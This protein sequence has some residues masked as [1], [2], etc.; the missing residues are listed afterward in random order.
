VAV[1]VASGRGDGAFKRS[2]QAAAARA[3][4]T[5]STPLRA[6]AGAAGALAPTRAARK[7]A[8]VGTLVPEWS[9]YEGITDCASLPE[10]VKRA[11]SQYYLVNTVDRKAAARVALRTPQAEVQRR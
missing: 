7:A 3:L 6:A 11:R 5:A 8:P 1:E 2:R 9:L 4:V 10:P